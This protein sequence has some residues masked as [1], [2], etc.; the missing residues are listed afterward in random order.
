MAYLERLDARCKD[1]EE[2]NRY[3]D[4]ILSKATIIKLLPSP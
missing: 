1:S 3:L 2:E 4:A